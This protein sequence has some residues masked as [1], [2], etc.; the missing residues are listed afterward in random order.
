MDL[1][2][3]ALLE[4]MR[5]EM[6]AAKSR[7][8]LQVSKNTE[9]DANAPP[10]TSAL[11][12]IKKIEQMNQSSNELSNSG[13]RR[14]ST[15]P[16]GSTRGGSPTSTPAKGAVT[17]TAGSTASGSSRSSFYGR[18]GTVSGGSTPAPNSPTITST[19]TFKS[20]TTP[21]AKTAPSKATPT[22]TS[23][24]LSPR[25][26]TAASAT[27]ATSIS[28]PTTSAS[29]TSTAATASTT[30]TTTTP[31]TNTT[32]PAVHVSLTT[33]ASSSTTSK[34]N[35][36]ASTSATTPGSTSSTSPRNA[37]IPSSSS[38][39]SLSTNA[40]T[41]ASAI[42]NSPAP[43]SARHSD[44]PSASKF[45]AATAELKAI[46][47]NKGRITNATLLGK[48]GL[49]EGSGIKRLS[50]L[51]A[52]IELK[53]KQMEEERAKFVPLGTPTVAMAS[54]RETLRVSTMHGQKMAHLNSKL[55]NFMDKLKAFEEKMELEQSKSGESDD[56]DVEVEEKPEEKPAEP[57]VEIKTE[58]I[59]STNEQIIQKKKERQMKRNTMLITGELRKGDENLLALNALKDTAKSKEPKEVEKDGEKTKEYR[60]GMT[61][62]EWMRSKVIEELINTE[63]DYINDL[64]L[65]SKV[66]YMPIREK[67]LLKEKEI[68]IIFSTMTMLLGV[69]SELLK[70]FK[71]ELDA[72]T[73]NIGHAFCW[74]LDFL[75]MYSGYCNNQDL[76]LRTLEKCVKTNS[77]LDHFLKEQLKN[78][79]CRQLPLNSYLIKPVQ[80]ITK[81][82]L[83]LRELLKNTDPS[84]PDFKHLERAAEHLQVILSGINENAR[85]VENTS[86]V[87]EIRE[88]LDR[89]KKII[90]PTKHIYSMEGIF[91]EASYD[92]VRKTFEVDVGYTVYI[93]FNN[94]LIRAIEKTNKLITLTNGRKLAA[95]KLVEAIP[96]E[97]LC[98]LRNVADDT[99]NQNIKNAFEITYKMKTTFGSPQSNIIVLTPSPESKKAWITALA[100]TSISQKN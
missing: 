33:T 46:R 44:S 27:S 48:E 36:A 79:E 80:R 42:P 5:A 37:T 58:D 35:S 92:V 2:R 60:D 89:G 45:L 26:A 10:P 19:L 86:K 74:M 94:L 12:M 53:K 73:G 84:H 17:V 61:K 43:T 51:Q 21:T 24:S 55:E 20:P 30:T 52:A 54:N 29:I 69:N 65:I 14:F 28:T 71:Q 100:T 32:T 90:D 78:P 59:I 1:E 13:T 88:R 49:S 47:E 16:P 81:Y 56:S 77:R 66:F 75:K 57:T 41:T 18:S 7:I 23:P 76:A 64:I 96:L 97:Y 34:P 15:P 62:I 82:P 9:A 99:S 4:R 93:L 22:S 39:S 91:R 40:A 98:G 6:Q 83:L 50:D 8:Q 72:G 3:K 11:A 31:T 68:E 95:L 25:R 38:A 87:H 85:K 67:K 63:E 70:V